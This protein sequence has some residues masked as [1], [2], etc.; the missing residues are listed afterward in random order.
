MATPLETSLVEWKP[1]TPNGFLLARHVLGN[2]LSGMETVVLE[3]DVPDIPV[4]GNFLSG[5][6]TEGIRMGDL[7]KDFPW[8]LP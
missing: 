1:R 7:T 5:M 4:L 6:E 3:A 8:K 2:F